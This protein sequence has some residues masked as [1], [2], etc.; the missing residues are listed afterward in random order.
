MFC[1]VFE[2]RITT[3]KCLRRLVSFAV[4]TYT[5]RFWT[6]QWRKVRAVTSG[7]GARRQKTSYTVF[8]QTHRVPIAFICIVNK[9]QK[10]LGTSNNFL[11]LLVTV[12][13]FT[14]T[15]LKTSFL[16]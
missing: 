3:L 15:N 8:Q 5:V 1:S 12:E 9:N 2:S 13:S 6:L 10:T 11:C 4:E 7:H 16:E 14:L